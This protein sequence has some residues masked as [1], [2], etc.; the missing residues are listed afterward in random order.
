MVEFW[1]R[2]HGHLDR[3]RT[4]TAESEGMDGPHSSLTQGAQRAARNVLASNPKLETPLQAVSMM[5]EFW[6]HSHG[7]LG[8]A[9]AE[10]ADSGTNAEANAP[11]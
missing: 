5:V 2:K 11:L 8:D 9:H 1:A 6:A 10:G 4:E 7:L 3:A